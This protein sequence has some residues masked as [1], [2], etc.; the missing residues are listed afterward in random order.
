[1][2]T[3][4]KQFVEKRAAAHAAG[5]QGIARD[6]LVMAA[7]AAQDQTAEVMARWKQGGV[8]MTHHVERRV[9]IRR[10]AE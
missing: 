4:Q 6:A 8:P 10:Q 3:K 5:I 9:A 2:D 1:M 7:R